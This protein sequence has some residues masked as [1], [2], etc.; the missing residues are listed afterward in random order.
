MLHRISFI[1]ALTTMSRDFM[2]GVCFLL[3]FVRSQ[4]ND[5]VHVYS[6]LLLLSYLQP[7]HICLGINW[8]SEYHRSFVPTKPTYKQSNYEL[9]HQK[10]THLSKL[11]D[12]SS[13]S[14]SSSLYS[15]LTV[16]KFHGSASYK[17]HS[18]AVRTKWKP[19]SKKQPY[20]FCYKHKTWS[21]LTCRLS[22]LR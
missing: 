22:E 13:F 14:S 4:H 3:C 12:P 15:S 2:L 1:I 21:M 7:Q 10:T 19:T 18:L 11:N 5:P 9:P 6:Q 17:T 20:T 16:T 8:H